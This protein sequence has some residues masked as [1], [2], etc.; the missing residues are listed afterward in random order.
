MKRFLPFLM[1]FLAVQAMQAQ[2]WGWNPN[3]PPDDENV[4]LTQTNL[5]IVW[6]DV[7]GATIDRDERITA[8]MKIIHNGDGNLNYADTIAHPGQT[9]DYEG[10]VALKY[11]GNSSFTASDKKPYSFRPL[12]APLEDGGTKEKVKILGMGKDNNWA[13]LAPYSDKSM[14]RDLLTFELS[15]PWMD[16]CP[17]GKYC[18]LYLDDIYYGIYIMCE[19]PTKGKRRLNLDD[20]GE[21]GDELTGGYLLEVDRTDEPT[22][23]SKYHPMKKNGQWINNRYINYQFKAP[24][25]EDLTDTQYNYITGQ[26]DLMEDALNSANYTNPETGYRKYMDVMSFVDFQIAQELSHNVDG[27]RL[28]SKIFK[29]RDS[30]DPRFKM[31]LWDFNIAFGN[32]DYYY[33]WYTNT[34]VYE[35]ND[36]LNS[37]GDTQLVPFWWYKLNKDPYYQDLLKQRWAQCRRANMREDRIIATIDSMATQLTEQGAMDRNSQAWPRWGQYVWPNKY[38]AQ[39][40]DDEVSH[41]KDWIHDRL[42]WMDQQL[43]FDPSAVIIGDVNGDGEI[44]TVDITCLYNYLLNGDETYLDTSDVDGDGYITTTDITVIYNIMLGN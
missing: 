19:L 6:I 4:Q 23:T 13:L 22:Y 2:W 18:E 31:V 29:W 24:E 44:T 17:T 5:P 28:S 27:Y 43:G 37:N 40:F 41:L 34:W 8:R 1:A 15:R 25:Y 14:M 20:P 3:Y 42:A 39:N 33:G 21:E 9:I 32:S 10:Y 38:I 16:F 35:N 26:I 36:I 7:D 12:N 11:R 30:V